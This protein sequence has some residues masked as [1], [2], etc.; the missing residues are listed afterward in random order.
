MCPLAYAIPPQSSTEL[1]SKSLITP[2]LIFVSAEICS[3]LNPA[4]S[5]A[6]C[7]DEISVIYLANPTL[8][9]LNGRTQSPDQTSFFCELLG[10]SALNLG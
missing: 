8:G 10:N 6:C 1:F 5:R 2:G 4:A 3:K 7:N 9:R